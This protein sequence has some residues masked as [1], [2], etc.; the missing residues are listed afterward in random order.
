MS[1]LSSKKTFTN[2]IVYSIVFICIVSFYGYQYIFRLLP[3]VIM[4]F[5]YEKYS[6]GSNE[7]GSYAA[8]YYLGYVIFHIPI[9][10]IINK[11]G[12]KLI[13]TLSIILCALGILPIMISDN[14][15]LVLFGRFITGIGS[16]TSIIAAFQVF[17]HIFPNHYSQAIGANVFFGLI[18]IILGGEYLSRMI[19]HTGISDGI[20]GLMILGAVLAL[21]S[22]LAIPNFK[23]SNDSNLWYEVKKMLKNKRFIIISLCAGLMVGPL[24]GFSDA[25]ASLF[26]IKIYDLSKIVA[27]K[28][29]LSV[30]MGMAI[31]SLCLPYISKKF[32][33]EY[34][35]NI[36]S[37]FFMLSLFLILMSGKVFSEFISI[38]LFC[39]GFF[40][41][42]QV[43]I[44]PMLSS[45]VKSDNAALASSI[46]NMI[47]MFFGNFFHK[48]IGFTLD[49]YSQDN[50]NYTN[51]AIQYSLLIIPISLFVA[52]I[53]LILIKK[54]QNN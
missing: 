52:M 10:I 33:I 54:K 18:I 30:L 51:L 45:F 27:D 2:Y 48:I 23:S 24:E 25:W 28:V 20:L 22:Y 19:N 47:I 5:I 36:F 46:T 17:R 7:F 8:S 34:N 26:L 15:Y 50:H 53:I 44:I 1:I 37:A 16:S 49:F 9:G 14:W 42:Y 21:V 41:A 38:L 40:S 6:I 3:N 31:G 4:P 13:I 43:V 39:I 12:C 11:F 29:I 32:K 35:I